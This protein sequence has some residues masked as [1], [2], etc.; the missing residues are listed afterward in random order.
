MAE[1]TTNG[2]AKLEATGKAFA[3]TPV[4]MELGFPED[5]HNWFDLDEQLDPKTYIHIEGTEWE[6]AIVEE[7][8][9]IVQFR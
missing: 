6:A 3:M 5:L 8:R 1:A 7:A 2:A 4:V 9:Q